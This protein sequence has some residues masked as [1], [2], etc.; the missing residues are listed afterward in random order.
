[1]YSGTTTMT[2]DIAANAI[3]ALLGTE[4]TER[5]IMVIINRTAPKSNNCTFLSMSVVLLQK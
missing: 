5:N 4:S 1:M 2:S 3:T